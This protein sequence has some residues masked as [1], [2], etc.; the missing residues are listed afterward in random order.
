MRSEALFKKNLPLIDYFMS[1]CRVPQHAWEET[2]ARC[3]RAFERACRKFQPARMR[4]GR[5]PSTRAESR[6][7]STVNAAT[8]PAA[9]M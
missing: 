2:H 6:R 5:R 9:S 4:T 7:A 1:K 8:D 3:L